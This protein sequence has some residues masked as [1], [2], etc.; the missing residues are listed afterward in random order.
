MRAAWAN[1]R[2]YPGRF[3]AVLLAI[4]IG[5]GFA[6]ATLV[7]TS[8]FRTDLVRS[9]GAAQALMDVEV[10]PGG[11]DLRPDDPRVTTASGVAA[12]EP[13]Y[14]TY[15]EM[16]TPGARGWTMVASIPADPAQRW[17]DL[18]TGAWPIGPDAVLTDPATATRNGLTVG[19]TLTFTDPDGVARQV[20]LTGL[21]DVHQSKLTG[22]SDQFFGDAQ[23][24]SALAGGY[25]DQLSV[26]VADG[27]SPEAVAA[28]LSA[29]LGDDAAVRTGA[30]AAE[31]RTSTVI[32]GTETL[33]AVLLAFAAIA[34]LVA[35]FVIANTFTILVTQRQRQL[36]LLR[37]VGASGQQVRRSLIIEAALVGVIGSLLGV[38]V[39]IGIGAVG[40]GVADIALG[41]LTVP[42]VGMAV[43]FVIGT[44]VTVL[45]ALVPASRAMRVTPLA[46]LSV[47]PT[48]AEDRRSG[49]LRL[50]L[51]GGLTVVGG[52]A[53]AAGVVLPS[54]LVA[55]A[56]G[57][58]SAA[59]LLLLLRSVLPWVLRLVG[60]SARLGGVPGRLATANALRHPGRSAATST[61]LVIAVGLIVTLQVAGASAR[62]SLSDAL[63]ERYP[64]DL[65]VIDASGEGGTLPGGL[66]D[67][68]D[69]ID[70][71]RAVSVA[72]T[73]A[74]IGSGAQTFPVTV[75]GTTADS[76]ALLRSP[77]PP[78][79]EIALPSWIVGSLELENGDPVTVTVNG[80]AV[81]LRLA[82]SSLANNMDA[83]AVVTSADLALLDPAATPRALWGSLDD[84]DEADT[85]IAQLKPLLVSDDALTLT[86]A[87]V[88]HAS[89]AEGLDTM[90]LVVVALLAVAAVIAVV[91]IG[92]TLGLSV[93]ERTRES[94]LLRAL[95]LRRGQLRLTI[96]IEAALLA[97]VGAVV[98]IAFG[99]GYGAVG[100]AATFAEIGEELV[101]AVPYGQVA[102]VLVLAMAA[103]VIASVLPAR[104]AAQATPTAALAEV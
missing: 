94:A 14:T 41:S 20:T 76:D 56:G 86:G 83:A 16:Q 72:G 10:Q 75:L 44:V 50:V 89:L 69:R 57:M 2:A 1:L 33:T 31:E 65:S 103:G 96:A 60:G 26:T 90:L 81:I 84:I 22:G 82:D 101:V 47:V 63:T 21:V 88:E 40:L 98:G 5:V 54:L 68:V 78:A 85:V 25:I 34:G 58:L 104:R 53:L 39:G 59:G 3:V 30:A 97:A 8:S 37:C 92:N 66:V 28:D 80:T 7:F 64:L 70:G 55:V 102:L 32:G 77:A 91:G 6:A 24:L 18:T 17:F 49:R 74:E 12:V 4:A 48:A 43:A 99:I 52:A 38:A 87:A 95:G 100:A 79:G 61:A 73:T 27:A 11:A 51:G 36:A 62:A 93:V 19:D 35:A 46:A 45:A 67:Q 29:A 9:V 42:P 13:R 15:V 23:L 71:V